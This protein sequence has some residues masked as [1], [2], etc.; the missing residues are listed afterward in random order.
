M[1]R[2]A[3]M[4]VRELDAD[5][6][7]DGYRA[8]TVLRP[9]VQSVDEFTRLVREQM[10]S[11]YRL[12]VADDPSDQEAGA[13]AAAGFRLHR[14]LAWGFHCYIDD[15]STVPEARGRGAASALLTWI[16]READAA[17]VQSVHLDS[18]VQAERQS[19]HRLY[20]TRGYRIS[21]YHFTA[22]IEALRPE[23]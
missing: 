13:V 6:C 10:R 16:H 20:F 2:K 22:D 1:E 23:Y 14:N 19:A 18:G 11:G 8:M 3:V 9:H 21:S 17:G 5:T 4:R 15:L 12:I 7:A